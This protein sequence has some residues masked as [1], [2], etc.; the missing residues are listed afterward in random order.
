[1]LP[2]SFSL[3]QYTKTLHASELQLFVSPKSAP[4]KWK[5]YQI[6]ICTL[7]TDIPGRIKPKQKA[8]EFIIENKPAPDHL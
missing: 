7:N 8:R 5:H 3:K 1:M 4:R 2:T 6:C